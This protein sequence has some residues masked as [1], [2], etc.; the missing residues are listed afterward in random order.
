LKFFNLIK[1]KY[2]IVWIEG[3]EP[4]D[5][6]KIK[7]LTDF[8]IKYTTKMTQAMR[9]KEDDIPFMKDYMKRHGIASWVI[10]SPNTFIR[11]SYVPKGTLLR[12]ARV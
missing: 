6:E 1:M 9:V 10:D 11:T 8:G 7:S 5:G 2:Y 3:L 4:R 12:A